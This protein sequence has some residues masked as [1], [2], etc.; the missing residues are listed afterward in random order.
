MASSWSPRLSSSWRGTHLAYLDPL[1]EDDADRVLRT[2]ATVPAPETASHLLPRFTA[3]QCQ[4]VVA[5]LAQAGVDTERKLGLPV[6]DP[7]TLDLDSTTTEDHGEQKQVATY[8]YEGM[9]SFGS[10]LC[11]WAEQRRVL[12]AALRPGSASDKPIFPLVLRALRALPG[13]HGEVRLRAGSNFL[14]A[15]W[16]NHP[17]R[18]PRPGAAPRYAPRSFPTFSAA[19][20]SSSSTAPA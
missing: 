6:G 4:A 20:R 19:S 7:V 11:T 3:R 10:V 12:A 17:R 13:G 1:H 16:V 15:V 18:D 9:R 8:N 14:Q 5:K 2:V